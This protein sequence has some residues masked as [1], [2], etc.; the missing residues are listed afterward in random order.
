MNRVSTLSK[1]ERV[2]AKLIAWGYT[3]KEIAAKLSLSHQTVQTHMKNIYAKLR[4]HKETDLI[5]WEIFQ[6]YGIADNPFKRIIAVF[7]LLLCLTMIV[8]E[9]YMVRMVNSRPLNA[10]VIR[11]RPV[12]QRKAYYLKLTA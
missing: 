12:R 8:N 10:R 2:I 6:E 9:I 1:R 5:R 3:Q 7:F 4:V 11:I